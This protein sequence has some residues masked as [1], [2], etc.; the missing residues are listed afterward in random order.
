[1]DA[2]VEHESA[3]AA[4][5]LAVA[6]DLVLKR[7]VKGVAIAEIAEKAHVGK[8]T[9]YLYWPTKEDLLLGLFARDFLA[10]VDEFSTAFTE[11]P[12]LVHPEHLCP[13][14]VRSALR[15]PFVHAIMTGNADLLGVL[16]EDPRTKELLDHLSPGTLM[17]KVLPVWRG[18]RMARTD[19]PIEAQAYA[20]RA[21]QIGF[22]ELETQPRFPADAS[23]ESP[24][25]VLAATVTA[26]LGPSTA[27]KA[28]V[29][30][31]AAEAARILHEG[32]T[33]VLASITATKG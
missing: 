15:R 14:L 5:I 26:L 17:L 23:V 3:K 11:N 29:A 9:L 31:V 18:H 19:W 20:L 6:R 13:M 8:G 12:D 28:E 32:S 30:A 22:V 24:D 10:A 27:G 1:M 2:L 21:L 33:A 16:A 25:E 7:G 4:R